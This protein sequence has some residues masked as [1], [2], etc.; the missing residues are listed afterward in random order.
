MPDLDDE[1]F[2]KY[3]KGF[4][5][6]PPDALPVRDLGPLPARR[7]RPLLLATAGLGA[8]A[9]VI[10]GVASF[11]VLNH[12]T[13]SETR[14]STSVRGPVPG[15]PLTLRDANALLEAAPSYKS[16]MDEL[17]FPRESSTMPNKNQS[18]LAVLAKEK[19]QL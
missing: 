8:I 3:L 7:A 4:R 9:A 1:Q 19:I 6:L 11:H 16:A 15:Q 5:P 13:S 2:E 17:A 18:A 12:H 14:P 10:L